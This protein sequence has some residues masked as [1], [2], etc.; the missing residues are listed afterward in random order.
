[1]K[2]KKE[3]KKFDASKQAVVYLTIE[4]VA[5]MIGITLPKKKVKQNKKKKN[6]P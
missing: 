3:N 4:E 5:E 2:P 6:E 1:M